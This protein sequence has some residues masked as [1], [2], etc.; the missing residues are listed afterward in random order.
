[1]GV[2]LLEALS[3]K[4]AV[5]ASRV[6]GIVDIIKDKETGLL[7][8]EKSAEELASAIEFLI[9]NPKEKERNLKK[10]PICR[11]NKSA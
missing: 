1:M 6:G 10:K 4:K 2:V 5:I 3:F 11:W 7:V 8:K 9:N